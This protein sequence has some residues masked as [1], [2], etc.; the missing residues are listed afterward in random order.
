MIIL[1]LVRLY[2]PHG[3]GVEKHV[4][5]LS[6]QFV[7]RGDEVW[8][9]TE[10]Y[11]QSLSE[12][13][14]HEN[15][16]IYRIPYFALKSKL[17]LWT[18]MENHI[19]LVDVAD[20]V[21]VH[22]VFWWYWPTYV[23]RLFKPVY[24]TFHGYEG[25]DPPTR[26]AILWRKMSE[27]ACRRAL[28]VGDFMKKWYWA[29]PDAITYGAANLKPL[30]LPD[31]HSAVFWGRFDEDTGVL[32][33]AEAIKQ[34][35]AVTSASFYG[36]GSQL[37]QLQKICQGSSRIEILPWTNKVE[38]VLAHHRFAFVSRYLSILEAMQVGRLVIA[39]Y[40]N[41]IKRDYLMCHP[42]VDNMVVAGSSREL[43]YKLKHIISRPDEERIMIARAQEWAVKQRWESMRDLYLRL[44]GQS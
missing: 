13:E 43:V 44:W 23:L 14:I 34:L 29:R 17:L 9:I 15:V 25:A 7:K 39:V 26:K 36:N 30:P 38:S 4:E 41:Q 42:M 11:D 20:V 16:K 3:G 5:K 35:R 12:Y 8:V 40:N 19:D 6:E 33:Y 27:I 28:C 31:N 2:W 24:I 37:Q 1:F 22:D 10:Q 18:W 32:L 21:H